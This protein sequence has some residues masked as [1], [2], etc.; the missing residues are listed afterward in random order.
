MF[1]LE[2]ASNYRHDAEKFVVFAVA[3]LAGLV[4]INYGLAASWFRRLKLHSNPLWPLVARFSPVRKNAPTSTKKTTNDGVAPNGM[5]LAPRNALSKLYAQ[6]SSLIATQFR[7]LRWKE[8]AA[9]RRGF[10]IAVSAIV[11]LTVVNEAFSNRRAQHWSFFLALIFFATTATAGLCTFHGEQHANSFR[12]LSHRG[13]SPSLVWLSKITVW[14]PRLI[15]AWI[16]AFFIIGCI[17][18]ARSFAEFITSAGLPL[19]RN[20]DA[21]SS[22]SIT[23]DMIGQ[24]ILVGLLLFSIGQVASI[25]F[26]KPLVRLFVALIGG[27]LV[28]FWLGMTRAFGVPAYLSTLPIIPRCFAFLGLGR[29]AGCWRSKTNAVGKSRGEL[30]SRESRHVSPLQCVFAAWK[31]PP[32]IRGTAAFPSMG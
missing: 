10:L 14:L 12:F 19:T 5:A 29:E 27:V 15:G 22:T 26:R 18:S 28:L 17:S 9:S 8:A 31:F 16:V 24:T 11:V 2:L 30:Q 1:F 3:I 23:T 6:K 7:F 25:C 4:V 21:L 20:F 13:V 32:T